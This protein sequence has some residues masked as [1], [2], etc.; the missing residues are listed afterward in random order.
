[1]KLKS[2]IITLIFYLFIGIFI[3]FLLNE[4]LFK[5]KYDKKSDKFDYVL[6]LVKEYYYQ[7]VDENELEINGINGMLNSLDPHSI[8]IPPVEQEAIEEEFEG[9]FDG[10]G[11]E[12]QVLNDTITVVSPIIGGPSESVGIEA[13]DR[14]IEIDN[15]KS[16]GFSNQDV[17]KNLRGPRGSKVNLTVYRPSLKKTLKFNIIRDVIPLRTVEASLIVSD[18]IGYIA[19]SKFVETSTFE[20]KDALKGLKNLGMKKLILDLRNNPGGFLD[21][22]HQIADL[23]IDGEKMIVYTKGRSSELEDVK[24]AKITYPYEQMPI[25]VLVNKGSAS[26]SEIVAGAIQDWDRGIIV[27]ETTFGKG[28]VQRPFLLN[29]SS[30][31]R[32]TIAKYFTPSGRVI[33]RKFENTK[34]YYQDIENR[35]EI[36]G[37]NID[38][39]LEFD[40]TTA[41]YHT[42]KGRKV[43]GG[44]GI[45]PDFIVKNK[46][47][48]EFTINLRGKNLF[49]KFIRLLLDGNL[50]GVYENYNG[51]LTRFYRLFELSDDQIN[52][53]KDFC[54]KNGVE[55]DV[56]SLNLDKN[57]IKKRLK[58]EIA[59]NY[60]KNNGWF[61]VLLDEDEQFLKARELLSK[62]FQLD[63]ID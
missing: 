18:S 25:A 20:M 43:I 7:E 47:L 60:W 45:T 35:E 49:Y 63:K 48:T 24:K 8:Y 32:I 1:M 34:E 30:A 21:Q 59:R 19:L 40:S 11:I 42:S 61:K 12:F 36:E 52:L 3:G 62:N 29:D 51:S 15:K 17:I 26:A 5:N 27:G 46:E 13:G 4:F 54:L 41:I 38:H 33:Q 57:Y 31:V 2:N 9:K 23:F 50:K 16:I 56:I 55:I 44:G 37:E 28:L 53:F 22:A 39:N 58:A 10:I 6:N 14:I